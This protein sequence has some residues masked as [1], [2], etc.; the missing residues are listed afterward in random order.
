MKQEKGSA[1][2]PRLPITPQILKGLH[3]FWQQLENK[4]DTVMLWAAC[5]LAFFGFLRSGRITVPSEAAFDPTCHLTPADVQVDNRESPSLLR[6][7]LKQSK[8]DPFRMGVMVFVRRTGSLL[9]PAAAVLAYLSLRPAGQGLLFK[10]SDGR[11]L[12]R[13]RLVEQ[14]R[15]AL[16][17]IGHPI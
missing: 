2:R 16:K 7:Q 9:C 13:Q 6:I 12:S 4:Y 3:A 8:T 1:V 15:R 17:G 14:L 11:A 5:T 10:F